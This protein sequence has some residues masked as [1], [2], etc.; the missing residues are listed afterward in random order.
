MVTHVTN[1]IDHDGEPFHKGPE[2][3]DVAML[4]AITR[5]TLS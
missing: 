5:I 3:A 1:A 4:A 2:D